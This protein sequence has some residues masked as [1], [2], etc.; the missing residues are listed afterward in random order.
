MSWLK[1]VPQIVLTAALFLRHAFIVVVPLL[2]SLS[3]WPTL[4]VLSLLLLFVLLLLL[5]QESSC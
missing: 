5:L 2:R 4:N 1:Y 3:T